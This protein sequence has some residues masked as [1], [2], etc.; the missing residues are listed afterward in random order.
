MKITELVNSPALCVCSIEGEINITTS[1]ELRK[2]CGKMLDNKTPLVVLD[3]GNV[4]YI[5]S[6][7]LATLVEILQRLKR[8]GG[9]LR[10]AAL[11]K[12]VHDLFEVTKLEKLFE[13]FDTLEK[14]KGP[15]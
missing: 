15:A 7:G 9:A 11:Q 6:S 12:K 3:M 8:Q 2:F 5:D 1:P 14:A 10:L 13:I 4:S